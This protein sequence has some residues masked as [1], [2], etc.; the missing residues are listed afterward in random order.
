MN[1][2]PG[3]RKI[4]VLRANALG[5]FVVAFTGASVAAGGLP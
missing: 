2:V 5:D 4:A 3:V 1:I